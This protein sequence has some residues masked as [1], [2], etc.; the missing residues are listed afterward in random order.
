MRGTRK[1]KQSRLQFSTKSPKTTANSGSAAVQ[2]P[3]LEHP[4]PTPEE[5]LSVRDDLLSLHGFPQEFVKYRNQRL[6]TKSQ[7]KGSVKFDSLIN[8]GEIDEKETVLDGLAKTILSQNTTELNSDRAFASLKSAFPTWDDVLA[9]ESKCVEDAIRCGGLAPTKSSCIKNL[10]SCLLKRNGKLC[11]EYLRGLSIEEVKAE[12]SLFK[13]IGPKTV[14]CV[15]MFHLQHDDFP[16]DTH[17]FQIAKTMGWVPAVADIKKTYLHLNQRI[18]DELKFDL[19]CL[20]YTHGKVCRKC[21]NSKIGRKNKETDDESCPLLA[22]SGKCVVEHE[23]P[24]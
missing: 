5:C 11:M 17:V 23:I 14:S 10:L 22:Y 21:S 6:K 18:P 12:L 7:L 20:L 13:G 16:V 8:D 1:R 24:N 15:L 4:R 2:A 3:F 9:A 19:N